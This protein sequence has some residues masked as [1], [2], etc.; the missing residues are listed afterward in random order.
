M[1]CSICGKP[2]VLIPS[3]AERAKKNGGKPEDY[4]KLF[5]HHAECYVKQRSAESVALMRKINATV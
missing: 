1:N 2:V 5:P 4:I 3:A